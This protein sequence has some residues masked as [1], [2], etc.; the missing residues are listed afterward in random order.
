MR[1]MRAALLI[2]ACAVVTPAWAQ[3][4][5]PVDL[6]L[7]FVVDA[8]GS[9]DDREMRLQRQGYA[10]ALANPQ[11]QK[12]IASGFLRS[13][14]V[15]YIE[16]AADGCVW[17]RVGWTRIAG[18]ADARSF[19]GQILAAPR[20]FCSGCNAIGDAVAF[21]TK[22]TLEN[23]FDGTR[24]VIDVSGALDMIGGPPAVMKELAASVANGQHVSLPDAG[25]ICNIANPRAFESALLDFFASL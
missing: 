11:V 16:F 4:A 7:A 3:K 20:D 21:A 14:A 19:G 12:A 8:S 5:T 2:L 6:E 24:K 10:D 23:A 15:T 1:A 25:H 9:I 18:E 13:V 17:Q 22:T